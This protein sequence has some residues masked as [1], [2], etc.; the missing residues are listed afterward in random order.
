M[1]LLT[2][3]AFATSLLLVC[4]VAA[5]LTARI[6]DRIRLGYPLNAVPSEADLRLTDEHGTRGRPYGRFKKWQLNEFGFRGPAMTMAPAPGCARVMVLGASETFGLYESDGMEYPAQLA[7]RLNQP[8]CGCF[9]VVNTAMVGLTVRSMHGL[10]DRWLAR[11]APDIVV[12]YP[13]PAFYL[14]ARSPG[15]SA[16]A[17]EA[18]PRPQPA[19]APPGEPWWT[20]RLLQRA[21]DR[22][23]FPEFI[24]RRRE[25]QWL[26]DARAGQPAGWLFES[27]PQDRLDEL[28]A[29]V[30]A[31]AEAVARAGARPIL[32]THATG[33]H[34]PPR[35]EERDALAA[36]NGHEPRA[37]PEAML[38]FEDAAADGM[39]ALAARRGIALVDAHAQLHGTRGFAP[40]FI[41]F[42][43]DGAAD[44][45]RLIAAPILAGR[46]KQTAGAPTPCAGEADGALQ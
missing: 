1:R 16:R 28:L 2:R 23:D 3:L 18:R 40:D 11:F 25:Q 19:A 31:L 30:D 35:D 38:A 45:A 29:D 12:I 6:E 17:A 15:E 27:V 4:G 13:T 24:Q 20:P 8:S 36:W 46:T 41:H 34:T 44:M 33:F 5:E 32:V 14:A 39:R 26:A 10:W 9:E 22:I 37:T 7:R 42:N 43:D 21:Q